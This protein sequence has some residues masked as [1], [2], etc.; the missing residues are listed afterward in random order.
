MLTGKTAAMRISICINLFRKAA[1]FGF[2]LF[3]GQI[4]LTQH[5][6]QVAVTDMRVDTQREGIFC[7]S[8]NNVLNHIAHFINRHNNVIRRA[9]LADK[10]HRFQTVAAHRPDTLICLQNIYSARGLADISGLLHFHVQLIFIEGFYRNNNVNTVF[11][12]RR[13]GEIKIF[14]G[15][16]HIRI[17]HIFDACRVYTCFHKLRH[18]TNRCH[19]VAENSQHINFI[20]RQGLQLQRHLRNNTQRTLAADNKL[21]HAV[22]CA[23]FFQRRA[24]V[25]NIAVGR[26]NLYSVNL[27]A[28]YAVAHCL[29]AS[30]IRRQVTADLA[31]VAARRVACI[32]QLIRLRRCL[33]I[34]RAHTGLCYHVQAFLI[35]L[36]NFVQAF[37]Q[38]HYAALIGNSAINDACT[39][40]THG[41]RDEILVAQLHHAGNF[42]GICRNN[43][44]I[45][46]MEAALVR[47]LVRL[48]A[49]ER[50]SI[51]FDIFFAQQRF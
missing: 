22:A 38:K 1:Q 47:L 30:G 13:A 45:R 37:H 28:R 33:D 7:H 25:N 46:Q 12:M 24:K 19:R 6:M 31:A 29:D 10:T 42:L 51:G 17:I 34:Q 21:L 35:Q 16:P 32:K 11:N 15:C 27:V 36:D 40:A 8:F 20:R 26:N 4:Q 41:Q 48:V 2:P 14:R 44:Y 50:I 9:H 3:I 43:H 5:D 23:A 39:A 18:N 49:V